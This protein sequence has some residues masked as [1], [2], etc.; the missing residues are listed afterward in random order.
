MFIPLTPKPRNTANEEDIMK[1]NTGANIRLPRVRMMDFQ[2][3]GKL[4]LNGADSSNTAASARVCYL[5]K[6]RAQRAFTT[7][8]FRFRYSSIAPRGPE[9]TVTW[10]ELRIS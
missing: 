7:N 3:C 9:I 1:C 10:K 6:Y 5:G 8:E 4:T 2:G